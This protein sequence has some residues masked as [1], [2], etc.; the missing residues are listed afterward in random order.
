GYINEDTLRANLYEIGIGATR[1]NF[2]AMY[3]VKRREREH[4][5]ELLNI[6]ED[7]YLKDLVTDEDLA[8]RAAEILVDEEA[9][10][11]YLDAAYIRKYKKPKVS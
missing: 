2:Y 7:G 6:Y 3:A 8:A 5:K 4:K 9:R 11:L 1:I 10:A